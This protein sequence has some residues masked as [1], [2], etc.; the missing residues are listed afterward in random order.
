MKNLILI[1][2]LTLTV[3]SCKT[4]KHAGCE[5]YSQTI[6]VKD[7]SIVRSLDIFADSAQ[8]WSQEQKQEFADVFFIKRGHFTVPKEPIVLKTFKGN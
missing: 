3:V 6:S 2:I 1:T 7:S 5:A 8:N 4:T